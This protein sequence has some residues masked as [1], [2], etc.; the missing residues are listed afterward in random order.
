MARW[1]LSGTR[2][3]GKGATLFG[4][5]RWGQDSDDREY[6]ELIEVLKRDFGASQ[7]ESLPCPYCIIEYWRAENLHFV[8]IYDL[9][10]ELSARDPRDDSRMDAFVA[11]LLLR[12][13]S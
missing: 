1:S 4:L 3:N 8:L 2:I 13:N 6:P 11:R 5:D 7:T 10:L 9:G 12:L